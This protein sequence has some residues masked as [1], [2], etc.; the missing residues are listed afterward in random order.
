MVVLAVA[1][2]PLT[3]VLRDCRRLQQLDEVQAPARAAYEERVRKQKA[4]VS[5]AEERGRS[6]DTKGCIDWAFENAKPEADGSCEPIMDALL[7]CLQTAQR[8]DV[9]CATVPDASGE[10][11][12]KTDGWRQQQ[13]AERHLPT[14]RTCSVMFKFVQ[15]HCH[16]IR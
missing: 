5:A 13:A 14:E 10:L 6:R 7:G 4:A 11:F 12:M 9:F 16:P 1:A 3:L 2:V 8:S 15:F